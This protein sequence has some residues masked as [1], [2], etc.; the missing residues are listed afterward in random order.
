MGKVFGK[1]KEIKG[2][3]RFLDPRMRKDLVSSPKQYDVLSE[4][5][6]YRL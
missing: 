3:M 2:L 4:T 1:G 6:R 5:K